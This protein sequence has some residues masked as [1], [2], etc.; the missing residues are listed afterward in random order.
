MLV[1]D[2]IAE[3]HEAKRVKLLI[4]WGYLTCLRAYLTL[5]FHFTEIDPQQKVPYLTGG[6]YLT[7]LKVGRYL[8]VL[9]GSSRSNYK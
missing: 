2:E 3:G 9:Y 5:N 4:F 7:L 6:C 8:K 1:R